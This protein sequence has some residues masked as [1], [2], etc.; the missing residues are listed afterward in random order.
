MFCNATQ[1]MLVF[2]LLLFDRKKEDGD[3]VKMRENP[4]SPVS[5]NLSFVQ[6]SELKALQVSWLV[7]KD[8]GKNERGLGYPHPSLLTNNK[9]TCFCFLFLFLWAQFR[10]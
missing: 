8:Q 2:F 5:T 1:R 10:D 7:A 3:T 9:Q 6:S 4:E